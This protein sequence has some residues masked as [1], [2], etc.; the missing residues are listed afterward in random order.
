MAGETKILHVADLHIGASDREQVYREAFDALAKMAERASTGVKHFFI[1]IAGDV[2]HKKTQY[3]G[4]DIENFHYLMR[5]L[6]RWNILMIA[7][8]HDVNL[9]RDGATDLLSPLVRHYTN[10]TYWRNTIITT[11]NDVLFYHVGMNDSASSADILATVAATTKKYGIAPIILYH[12]EIND[13]RYGTHIVR[14]SRIS[15][16]IIE[17]ARAVF[18]GDIHEQQFIKP[19]CAYS[20]SIIQQNMGESTRKGALLWTLS[21]AD[22]PPRGEFLEIATTS[23]FVNLDLRGKSLAQITQECAKYSHMKAAR[24]QILTDAEPASADKQIQ[25]VKTSLGRVDRINNTWKPVHTGGNAQAEVTHA[26]RSA[27]TSAGTPEE[28]TESIIRDHLARMTSCE[29]KKWT[30]TKVSF[31]HMYKYGPANCIDFAAISSREGITGVIAPNRAGK[32]SIIDVIVYG[33]FGEFLRGDKK[34]IIHHGARE[35]HLVVEF[36]VN[37]SKYIV[38]RMNRATQSILK[39]YEVRGNARV[40][41]TEASI[42]ATNR[43]LR[44]LVGTLDQFLATGLY[45]D[46]SNDIIKQMTPSARAKYVCGVLGL[47]SETT[48]KRLKEE[49][50]GLRAQIDAIPKPTMKDVGA[51]LDRE[52]ENV[53]LLRGKIEVL[54]RDICAIDEEIARASIPMRTSNEIN[55]ELDHIRGEITRA[56]EQTTKLRANQIEEVQFAKK[57]ILSEEDRTSLYALAGKKCRD[58]AA[59]SA[60]I[61]TL[62]AARWRDAG[63]AGEPSSIEDAG[64]L[65]ARLTRELALYPA[66]NCEDSLDSLMQRVATIDAELAR[67]RV[68]PTNDITISALSRRIYEIKGNLGCS[69]NDSCTCCA[70]NKNRFAR[71]L[72]VAERELA[73]ERDK[74]A[75]ISAEN[76]TISA[77]INE[78]TAMRDKLQKAVDK[79]KK[80]RGI[81][82]LRAWISRAKLEDERAQAQSILAA[83]DKLEA[84]RLYEQYLIYSQIRAADEIIARARARIGALEAELKAANARATLAPTK[85]L[86]DLRRSRADMLVQKSALDRELGSSECMV[87]QAGEQLEIERAYNA[88]V[89]PLEAKLK[90]VK[91]HLDAISTGEFKQVIMKKYI[92]NIITRTNAIL[93]YVA[94]FSVE[95]LVDELSIEFYALE[96]KT[97][98]PVSLCSGY[99]KFVV[100]LA[101]RLAIT[102]ALNSAPTFIMID[103]GFGCLDSANLARIGEL[104]AGMRA[105]YKFIFVISHIDALQSMINYPLYIRTSGD[106]SSYIN[107]SSAQVLEPMRETVRCPCGAEV[108][109]KSMANHVKTKKHITDMMKIT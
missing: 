16:E 80:A 47:D 11:Y 64:I 77:Q 27:L 52:R 50:K 58:I 75:K 70:S 66:D 60:E 37:S 5:V 91:I 14:D 9:A 73:N 109:Q 40:D 1:L 72:V 98:V 107:D 97:R 32:S 3:S 25:Y 24:V 101:F 88:K 53:S 23:A 26:L 95:C 57:V 51:L 15:R 84:A 102:G 76:A 85:K 45:C 68:L 63:L 8:N 39:L 71:N 55:A 89:P 61:L 30:I 56:R 42:D 69:F 78:R 6:A 86:E 99:Q 2:F 20:G 82:L 49:I 62:G 34:S 7:G 79:I 44:G 38:D 17:S 35:S 4:D 29:C 31:D 81:E 105:E 46:A 59:I 13:A 36:M 65:I 22:I 94:D 103:E 74:A 104:F 92:D 12:G 18:A 33:L 108:K 96:G 10:I 67:L 41:I 100:S 83:K 48:S 93:H 87:K 28:S 43:K 21:R 90:L 106:G 19:T 54:T